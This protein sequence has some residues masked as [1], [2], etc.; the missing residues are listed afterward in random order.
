MMSNYTFKFVQQIA[1]A[2]NLNRH[3]FYL[4]KNVPLQYVTLLY[5]KRGRDLCQYCI[6]T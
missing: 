3:L 1:P 4:R 5:T 2:E 6:A